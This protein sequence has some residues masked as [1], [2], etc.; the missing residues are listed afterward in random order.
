MM[1]TPNRSKAFC[2]RATG[3]SLPGI[4]REEKMTASPR[5]HR[6][7]G[8]L[9]LGDPG[10]SGA[11]FA[12]PAGADDQAALARQIAGQCVLEKWRHVAEIAAFPGG[13]IGSLQRCAGHDDVAPGFSGCPGDRVQSSDV[14]GET[15]DQDPIRA[16]L[17][18][19]AQCRDNGS[20]RTGRTAFED[21][22]RVA[23]QGGETG[24]AQPAQRILVGCRAHYRIGI[25]L[26]IPGVE[27]HAGSRA[28]RD[29]LRLRD[30]VRHADE[31]QSER[32]DLQCAI[33]GDGDQ[34]K[35]SQHAVVELAAE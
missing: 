34:P 30:R 10:K 24:I 2:S 6:D 23:D 27:H 35:L 14:R 16:A 29:R 19:L 15:G 18:E 22:G 31:L 4:T 20:F 8:V 25:E 13:G 3:R 11:R 28:N 17:H 1:S 32:A 9:P 33:L 7:V 5:L 26:P 12:L 21:V